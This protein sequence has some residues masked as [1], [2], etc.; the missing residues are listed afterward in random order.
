ME[1]GVTSVLL[2]YAALS[3]VIAGT[4]ATYEIWHRP[5]WL[6]RADG[7]GK[8]PSPRRRFGEVIL[9]GLFVALLWP[10][11]A[12]AAIADAWGGRR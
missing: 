5:M 6:D 3:L 11:L 7:R 2:G 4:A 8:F 9:F 10:L 12:V 1:V